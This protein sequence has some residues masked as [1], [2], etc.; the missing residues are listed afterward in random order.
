MWYPKI[1]PTFV[2][3]KTKEIYEKR[4]PF[5]AVLDAAMYLSGMV[6]CVTIVSIIFCP[7]LLNTKT[8]SN[9][10]LMGLAIMAAFMIP[11]LLNHLCFMSIRYINLCFRKKPAVII[12]D[13]ALYMYM[14]Y[15]GY[16]TARWEDIVSFK[17]AHLHKYRDGIYP[18]YKDDSLNH[19]PLIRIYIGAILTGHLTMNKEDLLAELNSHLK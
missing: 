8:E 17:D 7:S 3:M 9:S 16:I 10:L 4:H 15:D 13:D 5:N 14:P 1:V 12:T 6:L 11:V 19:S 18:I 2:P